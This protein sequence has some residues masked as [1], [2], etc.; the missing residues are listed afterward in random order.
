MALGVKDENLW[1]GLAAIGLG[2]GLRLAVVEVGEGQGG[3]LG[4]VLHLREAVVE[5][6]VAQFLGA[7]GGG[8]VGVDGKDLQALGGIVGG[9]LPEPGHCGL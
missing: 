3:L 5:G 8:V 9:Q 4:V 7:Q 2:H 1:R 6:T